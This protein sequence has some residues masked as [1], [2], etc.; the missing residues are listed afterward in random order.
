MSQII[1]AKI[2]FRLQDEGG[3]QQVPSGISYRPHLVVENSVV[4]LGVNFIEIPDQVQL[5]VPYTQKMR[6]MYD[7]KEY[8]LLQKGTKFKIMEGPNIVGEGCVL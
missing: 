6:L 5:G 8:E 7:L 2:V 3:R 1:E 4:Y